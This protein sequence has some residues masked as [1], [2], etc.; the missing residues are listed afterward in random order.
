MPVEN[1]PRTVTGM[2]RGEFMPE[3]IDEV[4]GDQT[5]KRRAVFTVG[6]LLQHS[7]PCRR[8][9]ITMRDDERL[10]ETQMASPNCRCRTTSDWMC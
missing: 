7:G 3:I 5:K 2:Q 10:T 6:L 1:A 8:D 9:C 4:E